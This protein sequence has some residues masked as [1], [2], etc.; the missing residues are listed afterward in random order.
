MSYDRL[1]HRTPVA[2]VGIVPCVVVVASTTPVRTPEE[3]IAY[4][5]ANRGKLS[6]SSSGVGNPQH[7]AGE[8]MN[9]MAGTHVLHR[10]YPGA[11]PAGTRG[12]VRPRPLSLPS[13]PPP[14][15]PVPGRPPRPVPLPPP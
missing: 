2:L 5:R 3:L 1:R 13:P 15:A 4:A 14:L 7:V 6:F 11:A 12:P 10:P 9:S 8:L